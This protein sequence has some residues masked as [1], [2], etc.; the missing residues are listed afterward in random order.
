VT[1]PAPPLG[2]PQTPAPA[3]AGAPDAS[4]ASASEGLTQEAQKALEGDNTRAAARA[5]DLAQRATQRDPTNAEA[6]LTLGAA[7]QSL[8]R[9]AQA[10][11]AY[12]S[13]AQKAS[14][15]RVAE[16]RALAGMD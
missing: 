8:G 6:W 12:R 10:M 9:K 3:P 1:G 4:A 11:Q 15:P 5:L 16:C 14:G 13:C 7:C 2:A